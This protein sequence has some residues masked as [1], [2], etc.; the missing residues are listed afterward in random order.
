MVVDA[1]FRS[2]EWLD[3]HIRNAQLTKDDDSTE[4]NW[5]AMYSEPQYPLAL[6]FY[7]SSSSPQH[8]WRWHGSKK[9]DLIYAIEQPS[10]EPLIDT[11][12]N[13]YGYSE[14]SPIV[15]CTLDKPGITGTNLMWKGVAELR[16]V[17]EAYPLGSQRTFREERPA[18]QHL[19]STVLHATRCVLGYWRD[20]T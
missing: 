2:K 13:V 12:R 11:T 6:E 16:Y 5:V 8:P 9:I 4:I 3:A 18:T 7:G 14:Q 15:V 10:S 19:G 17:G 1:R 20:T